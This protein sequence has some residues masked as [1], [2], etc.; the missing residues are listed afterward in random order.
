MMEVI[1]FKRIL[2]PIDDTKQSE[3]AGRVGLEFAKRLEANVIV[4]HVTY[5]QPVHGLESEE[6]ERRP[7]TNS[8][9]K[10]LGR[11]A[12]LGVKVGV[13]M[14]TRLV[15]GPDVAQAIVELAR[16]TACELIVMGTHAREGL[17][18]LLLGSVAERVTRLAPQPVMLLRN[19]EGAMPKDGFNRILVPIDGSVPAN[20]ALEHAKLLASRL[21]S[22][23][24]LLHVIPD[25]SLP[26]G[27]VTGASHAATN[28]DALYADL[29]R[30]GE[31]VIQ[32]AQA[33][34]KSLEIQGAVV[35]TRLVK[36]RGQDVGTVILGIADE[37]HANLIV[38]GTHGR[39]GFDRLLLGSVAERVA[40]H[41]QIPVMLVRAI[42]TRQDE[43]TTVAVQREAVERPAW[44]AS[45]ATPV[46]NEWRVKS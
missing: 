31:R 20:L 16:E 18:R 30:N 9:R 38:I 32:E 22:S 8:A 24:I 12:D 7:Y 41:A 45:G 33:N 15:D 29:H 3:R 5:N 21:G 10:L 17:G 35:K 26:W 37:E 40:H 6:I 14:D 1:M 39:R 23:L 2:I 28:W 34:A 46:E 27:D 11:W 43:A 36:A 19:T 44:N 42:S 13:R 25:V 4:M